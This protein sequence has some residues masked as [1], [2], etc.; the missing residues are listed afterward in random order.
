MCRVNNCCL[1]L[2]LRVAWDYD[3]VLKNT[4]K[5]WNSF[6]FGQDSGNTGKEGGEGKG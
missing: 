6:L 5:S 4:G 1:C 3:R 2:Y